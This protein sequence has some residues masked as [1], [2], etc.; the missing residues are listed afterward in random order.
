MAF[1]AAASD[2]LFGGFA[3]TSQLPVSKEKNISVWRSPKLFR[4]VL[5]TFNFD[6]FHLYVSGVIDVSLYI[7]R[8]IDVSLL[9]FLHH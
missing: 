7:S 6:M 9:Y 4:L 8:I 5:G 3:T 1:R 2:P